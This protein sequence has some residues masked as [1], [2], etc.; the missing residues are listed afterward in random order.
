MLRP[1]EDGEACRRGVVLITMPT[2]PR[3]AAA[4]YALRVCQNTILPSPVGV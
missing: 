2:H 1:Y 4:Y 3:S